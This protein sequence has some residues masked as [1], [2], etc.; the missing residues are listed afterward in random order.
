LQLVE[1]DRVYYTAETATRSSDADGE[2]SLGAEVLWDDGNADDENAAS[3]YADAEALCKEELVI[4]AAQR[5]HHQAEDHH[6]GA[7]ED[8][9][10]SMATVEEGTSEYGDAAG[11]ES[12]D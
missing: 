5:G 1:N 10:L 2:S 6:E 12:L 4:R 7:K 9:G 8:D 11:E 3:A